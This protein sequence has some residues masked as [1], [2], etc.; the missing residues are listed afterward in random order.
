VLHL[1]ISVS[2]LLFHCKYVHFGYQTYFFHV[3]DCISVCDH[4]LDLFY[5]LTLTLFFR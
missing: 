2:L 3:F 1:E 5:A 4:V